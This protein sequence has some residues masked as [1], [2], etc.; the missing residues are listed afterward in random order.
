MEK[1]TQAASKEAAL[2]LGTSGLTL[3]QVDAEMD[4]DFFPDTKNMDLANE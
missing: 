1:Q 3:N 4:W 2:Y